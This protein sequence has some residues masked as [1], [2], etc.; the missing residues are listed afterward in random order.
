MEATSAIHT[1]LDSVSR[2][3][4]RRAAWTGAI[5]LITGLIA[6]ALVGPLIA[7]WA[8]LDSR[9]TWIWLGL[10]LSTLVA[11]WLAGVSFPK[12]RWRTRS[13]SASYVGNQVETIASDLLSAVELIDDEI[14]DA[15]TLAGSADLR[16]A[17]FANTAE[18]LAPLRL[19]SLVPYS[20]VARALK[21]ACA[22]TAVYLLVAIFA[23]VAL[24]QGWTRL[25]SD[26]PEAAFGGANLVDEPLVGDVDILI[27]FPLYTHKASLRLPASSGDF[28]AMPGS[29]VS[30]STRA[31]GPV[32]KARMLLFAEDGL[33]RNEA[34]E[35]IELSNQGDTLRASFEVINETYYRFEVDDGDTRSVESRA[36]KIAIRADKTPTVQLY[37]PADELDVAKVKRIELAYVVEDDYGIAKVELVYKALGG[38]EFRQQLQLENFVA[39]VPNAMPPKSDQGKYLWDLA[40]L[41]LRPGV[42][43]EYHLE[44]TD[45][46]DVLGPNIGKSKSFKLR[47]YSPRERH[48]DLI[49][50][51]RQLAEHMLELLAERL[52]AAEASVTEHR[53]IHRIAE[54]IVVEMGSLV[55][56]LKG[57]ELATPKLTAAL[58]ALRKNMSKRTVAE[59]ALLADLEKRSR[60]QLQR[61]GNSSS[62]S[63]VLPNKRLQDSDTQIIAEL[64]DDVLTLSDWLQR[65]DMENLLGISDE[66]KASQERLKKLFEE[67]ERTGSPELLAE[68]ERELRAL[69]K[70][71]AEMASKRNTMPED[72]LDRFVNADAMQQQQDASCLAKVR[73]LLA[74]GDA[75]AAQEQMEKCSQEMDEGARAL[76]E[77]LQGLR[78]DSF[79]E[80]EKA[81]NETMSDLADLSQ[82]Q[83]DIADKA[84]EIYKRYADSVSKLQ[85]GRASEAQKAAKETLKKLR[86]KV[87]KIPKKGLTRFAKEE[88]DILNKRLDDT[89]AMLKKGDLAEA[90][91]MARHANR[92]LETVQDEMQIEL[93]EDWS[94]Q[95][96]VAEKAA[97]S[98][99]PTARKLVEELQKATPSPSEI[100][101]KGDKRKLEKLRR[102]QKSAEG[103]AQKLLKRVD[104]QS[105]KLPGKAGEAIGEGLKGAGERMGQAAQLMRAKDPSS[106]REMAQQAADLL[107]KAQKR[108]QG[109]ARQKQK[110]GGS[111]WRDEPVRIP[112]AEDYKAPEQYRQEILDAM[113]DDSAPSGFSEQVKRYYRDI[114]Q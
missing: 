33:Q 62:A 107:K 29:T 76:E 82:D 46:D 93:D 53:R 56:S 1:F 55:A 15:G 113:K 5:Y 64:E 110:L 6:I 43:I 91:S 21:A 108:A 78:S 27:E 18:R 111:S 52:V 92:S 50:R 70:R 28:E 13:A 98:A 49:H 96:V 87:S 20:P 17:L 23:P 88:L 95:A 51:Q 77:A 38:K 112:G 24:A 97:R 8:E 81:F 69:E 74:L 59:A 4:R 30:F 65:Q 72:V 25:L 10:A 63:Q 86:K 106:A 34:D 32:Q 90:L 94:R 105:G 36:H 60:L 48:E 99:Q 109:A 102:Q 85:D 83:Q 7:N 75:E 26:P 14:A 58:V 61:G 40:S 104:G 103:R 45:N 100:M 47:L 44:V 89:E 9:T 31:L 3:L 42:Q 67:Y 41:P 11:C 71:L 84:E 12:R 37:A 35:E 66:I 16:S 73:E 19:R 80:E 101:S 54:D 114:I 39:D 22:T 2:R 57:D 68:I 79:S